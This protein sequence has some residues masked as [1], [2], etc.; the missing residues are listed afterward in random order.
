MKIDEFVNIS[1][2]IL[3]SCFYNFS[4]FIVRYSDNIMS[5]R[6]IR[7]SLYHMNKKT[8]DP[9]NNISENQYTN[10]TLTPRNIKNNRHA[11]GNFLLAFGK[12]QN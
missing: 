9:S 10:A 12:K 4:K 2:K 6:L 8:N 11:H 7:I 3:K 5:I 1:S